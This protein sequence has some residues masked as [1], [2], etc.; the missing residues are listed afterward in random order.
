LCAS[1]VVD[2]SS[3]QEDTEDGKITT[4]MCSDPLPEVSAEVQAHDYIPDYNK[5]LEELGKCKTFHALYERAMLR[6]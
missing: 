4:E 5:L 3:V 2:K 1:E 6:I